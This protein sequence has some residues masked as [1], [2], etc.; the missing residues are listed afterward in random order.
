MEE[1]MS[2][3]IK[4][5]FVDMASSCF[6]QLG[7]PVL[8]AFHEDSITC[9]DSEFRYADQPMAIR[10]LLDSEDDAVVIVIAY[11]LVPKEKISVVL[12]LIGRINTCLIVNRYVIDPDTGF[13]ILQAGMCVTD[14]GLNEKEVLA[15]LK[16]ML[17]DNY[18]FARV[19]GEQLKS[20]CS[21]AEVMEKYLREEDEPCKCLMN[22]E[23][24]KCKLH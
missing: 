22:L 18:R 17:A 16:R 12:E 19:I 9:L 4:K 1:I 11:G 14:D 13:L 23:E 2:N 24:K 21:P 7:L 3:K 5:Q 15:L 20:T 10:V 8:M 6:S